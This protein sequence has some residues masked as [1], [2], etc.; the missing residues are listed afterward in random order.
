VTIGK[1]LGIPSPLRSY[2]DSSKLALGKCLTGIEI[3]CENV[4]IL[5]L[6]PEDW[7]AQWKT[8]KDNSL[9]GS[10][11]E[12]ILKEPLFGDDLVQA[13]AGFCNWAKEKKFESNY[14]TGLHIHID[15]RNLELNQLVAMVVYYA[16]FEKV[17]FRYIGNNREGSIFC[18]PFYK[19]EGAVPRIVQAFKAKGK[20]MKSVAGMIDRYGALNLN[21][22]S[23]YGSVEW[24]H[25]Q[26]SFEIETIIDWI[27]IA[28]SFKKFAKNNPASPND[29]IGELSKFGPARLLE[30]ILGTDLYKKVWYDLAEK[31]V[32]MS[33]V[34]IA[35]DISFLMERDKHTITWD[36]TRGA[37][38]FGTN[39][40]FSKW[41]S[42][43]AHLKYEELPENPFSNINALRDPQVQ[44]AAIEHVRTL[45]VEELRNLRFN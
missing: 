16:L 33:G 5:E 21:A 32:W 45:L 3:E 40:G 27:N 44:A 29:L 41:A 30:R 34:P 25:F 2:E 13:L 7:A 8:D 23:K 37:L 11:L 35:Q 28:Q 4:K 31:D 38:K 42:K 26:T 22:L 20:D 24:R 14:R 18:M 39:L 9:R 10:A 36:N 12:F 15:V 19:A 1:T 6:P 43:A 17:L